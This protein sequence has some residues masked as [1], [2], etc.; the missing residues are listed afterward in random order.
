MILEKLLPIN[1]GYK[2]ISKQSENR[3]DPRVYPS[4]HR[5]TGL[6]QTVNHSTSHLL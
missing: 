1:L 2:V 3:R 4:C 5:V 6:T